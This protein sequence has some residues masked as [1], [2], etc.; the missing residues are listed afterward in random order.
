M[1]DAKRDTKLPFDD[2]IHELVYAED[3]LLIHSD[4]QHLQRYMEAVCAQG[5]TYG[6]ELN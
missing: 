1:E 2:D 4:A 3:T 6:L 5:R